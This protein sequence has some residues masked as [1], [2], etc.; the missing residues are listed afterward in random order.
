MCIAVEPS[1]LVKPEFGPAH[2]LRKVQT[3]RTLFE[4]ITTL[5]AC[6]D[7]DKNPH[8]HSHVRTLLIPRIAYKLTVSIA[9][10]RDI[11]VV[12]MEISKRD[13]GRTSMC[14]KGGQCGL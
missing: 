4:T 13:V 3:F 2:P 5:E 1:E 9:T 11:F 8:E 10:R 6:K 14:G 7:L 12:V